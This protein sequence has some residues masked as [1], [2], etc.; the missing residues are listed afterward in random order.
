ISSSV[1]SQTLR[2]ITQTKLDELEKK[3]KAFEDQRRQVLTATERE[4]GDIKRVKTLAA[5]TKT[6]FGISTSGG[7]VVRG[8]SNNPRLKID[9]K[10]LDRF[11]AQ[12]R[13]DPTISANN[14]QQWQRTLLRH[15]EKQKAVSI[16]KVEDTEMSEFKYV[17]G[18]KKLNSRL[19]LERSAF[20]PVDI[21][22][23][24]VA[25]MLHLLFESTADGSLDL[26]K[27][28]KSL[29]AQTIKSLLVSDL[30]SDEKRETLRDFL[31]NKTI[32]GEIADA[33]RS[34]R[35]SPG[36]WKSSDKSIPTIDRKRREFY[37]GPLP[38]S[39]NFDSRR[40]AIYRRGY[41]LSQLLNKVTQESHSAE[42][43]IEAELDEESFQAPRKRVKQSAHQAPIRNFSRIAYRKAPPPTSGVPEDEDEAE[44]FKPKNA[45][46]AKQKL[47]HLLS[48]ETLI[49]TR[50]HAELTCFRSQIN[51]LYP[52]LPHTTINCVLAFF[53]VSQK[54]LRF[55]NRFL[56]APL[57]FINE[58]SSKLRQREN[59]TPGSHILSEVF[60]E[61]VHFCLD[62]QIN[63]ETDGG[64]LWRTNND[65]WYW[66][67]S[68]EEREKAWSTIKQFT[69]TV[70]I[71][72]N[73]A[74][75]GAARVG[76]KNKEAS[77]MISLDVGDVLPLSQIRWGMLYLNPASGRFEIDQ[78]M[79]DKH[80]DELARQ[81]KDKTND[82]FAWTRAWNN[83]AATFFT[84]NFGKP[85]HCFGQQHVDSTLATHERIQR[86]IFSS[87]TQAAGSHFERSS[88]KVIDFRKTIRERFGVD[89]VPD[90]YFYF[91]TELG[92]LQI[93]N[94]LIGLLQIREKV[95]EN[96]SKLLDDFE[97]AEKE[98]YRLAQI[99]FEEG[100][101]YNSAGGM[102]D[103]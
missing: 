13:Y 47:L 24:A 61:L 51:S 97:K 94:P 74:R 10:N 40:L 7:R 5:G 42:G 4:E 23:A 36:V 38:D 87:S 3:R 100:E 18:A 8:S 39:P 15:F 62:F 48:A 67:S 41:F 29:R 54:W 44:L 9:L 63:R 37:L 52:S 56:R 93:Q 88:G 16:D 85:A 1:Y 68:H 50:L 34:F 103:P 79:V 83:Y 98:A 6:C 99:A 80:M 102:L 75:S 90:G 27:A 53:G 78:A 12:A 70:G 35:N 21:D 43:D 73:G 60:G 71:E 58:D 26:V 65:F 45:I 89:N 84:A 11:L 14:L 25:E 81:L 82:V 49:K 32:L 33:L 66:S 95:Y 101:I 69:T 77:D 46:D 72:L 92:G 20:E 64:L 22:R 28:L 91:P 76:R 57:R 17:S 59:G 96:P 30:L 55:F 31:G 86:R 19:N 2:S